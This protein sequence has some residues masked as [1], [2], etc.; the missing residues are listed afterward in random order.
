MALIKCSECGHEVSDKA[1]ACPNCGCPIEKGL[2]C[3]ECGNSVSPSDKSCPKCGNPIKSK[4]GFN[5]KKPILFL[6]ILLFGLGGTYGVWYLIEGNGEQ[7]GDVEI[8]AELSEAVHRYDV[9][10]SF[11]EGLSA[12][13]K[14]DK[15]G[16]INSKGEEVIPCKYAG[17]CDFSEGLACVRN[18]DDKYGFI[19]KKGELVI[20]CKYDYVVIFSEGLARVRNEDNKYGFIDKKGEL[21]IPCKYYYADYFSEG[22]ACVR[23]EDDKYGFIDKKG[24]LVIP[25]KYDNA[26]FFSE[27]L[28]RVGNEDNQYGFIDKKGELVIPCKYGLE[29]E[30]FSEGLARV[31]NEDNKYGFI[32]KKGELVIPCKYDY[33]K[34]FSE[35]LSAVCKNDKRS[36]INSKGDEVIP[37]KYYYADYFSEGLACVRNEDDKYGFIDKKGELVIPCKYDYAENF[38]EGLAVTFLNCG[39]DEIFG[40]VDKKGN[41]TFTESDFAQLAKHEKQRQEEAKRAEEERKRQEEEARNPKT[42]T[43]Y[44]KGHVGNYEMQDYEGNYGAKYFANGTLRTDYIK[45]P[46]GKVWIFKN[47][48]Y[49]ELGKEFGLLVPKIC[50]K[51]EYDQNKGRFLDN[52]DG[53]RFFGGQMFLILCRPAEGL[54]ER[55]PY[56]LEVN[57]IEKSETLY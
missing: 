4:N 43:I 40:F 26:D 7:G 39:D 37:C 53:E 29:T 54:K 9:V 12:V 17:A 50:S 56:S 8:T 15:W 11:H 20:P 5:W 35:G 51:D 1:S 57:F 31:R 25:C 21:V 13:C 46:D 24:E 30:S 14:N 48:T 16:Y 19:D 23:T 33:A 36:Y 3:N 44:L 49:K 47:Y 27:G 2:I 10:S 18:E 34:S 55:T 22:L 52:M 32:D 41:D 6:V 45:V 28:A 42:I 38:S